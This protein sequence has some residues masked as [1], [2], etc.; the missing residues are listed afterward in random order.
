MDP[1]AYGCGPPGPAGGEA[2]SMGAPRSLAPGTPRNARSQKTGVH[3]NSRPSG[4]SSSSQIRILMKSCKGSSRPAPVA[5]LPHSLPLPSPHPLS[6]SHPGSGC[7]SNT[8][9]SF[10]AASVQGLFIPECFPDPLSFLNPHHSFF[11]IL[12]T[13]WHRIFPSSLSVSLLDSILFYYVLFTAVP[14]HQEICLLGQ[15]HKYLINICQIN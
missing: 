13:I 14:L 7:C 11:R 5:S 15:N 4:P 6:S 3:S 1:C 10:L 8:P 9:G 12:I 2:V